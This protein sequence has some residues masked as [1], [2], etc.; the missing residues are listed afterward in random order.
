MRTYVKRLVVLFIGSD[1][2]LAHLFQGYQDWA[3]GLHNYPLKVCYR[4]CTEILAKT[5][6]YRW[7]TLHM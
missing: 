6:E 3:E 5:V 4:M 7:I 1:W 2:S